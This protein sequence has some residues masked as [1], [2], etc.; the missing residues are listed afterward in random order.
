[1]FQ[2]FGFWSAPPF[3]WGTVNPKILCIVMVGNHAKFGGCLYNSWSMGDLKTWS[4][5]A[6]PNDP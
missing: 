2:K 6:H 3:W 5:G 4:T 1:M